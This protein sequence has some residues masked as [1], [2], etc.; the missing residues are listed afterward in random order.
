MASL[1]KRGKTYYARYYVNGKQKAVCLHTSSYPMAK[2]KL[3]AI[4]SRLAL[5]AESP[6]PTRTPLPEV[7]SAYIMN[8]R[9]T[10]T[11]NTVKGEVYYLRDIF[12]PVCPELDQAQALD[13]KHKH[14][15]RIEA[16]YLEQIRTVEI[17]GFLTER[18]RT[19]GL[20]PKTGNHYRGIL[21]RL[22]SWAMSQYGVHMPNDKNPASR[23]EKYKERAKT[24]RFLTL[25]QIDE[26]LSVLEDAPHIRTMVAVYIFAGLRRE[27]MLWL[28][29]DDVKLNSGVNGVLHIQAKTVNAEFWQ[30]K[31]K[32][33]R[34]VPIS[35]ALRAILDR[36]ERRIV[37]GGW[38]LPSP[39]GKRWNPDNFSQDLRKRNQEARLPWSCLDYRHTFGSHLAMKGESL[40]KI[41]TLL[42]NSPEICRR[43]YAA[44][45]PESLM[46]SVEFTPDGEEP[47]APPPDRRPK[48]YIV[49]KPGEEEGQV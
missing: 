33:N 30:P 37:P 19:R 49:P 6:M 2:Q 12:G 23:V 5:G 7:L 31:T 4:E 18:M 20:S 16:S 44:L 43:H 27:E 17:V 39:A 48:L 9:I 35:R 13:R 40:Y 1:K 29:R 26:Q 11:A 45:M 36:Y 38:Y 28:T 14:A 10:K 42:G 21:S 25:E 15:P 34:V 46:N 3:R 24:I 32:T 47:N 22:F 8:A 41:A